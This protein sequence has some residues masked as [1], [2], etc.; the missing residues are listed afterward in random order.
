MR[1]KT[2]KVLHRLCDLSMIGH[3]LDSARALDPDRL[4]VVVGHGRQAVTDHLAGLPPGAGAPIEPV[5]Q[6][7]QR[8]TGHAVR[9]VVEISGL[10]SGTVVVGCGDIPLLRHETLAELTRA[11]EAAGNAVT[12]LSGRFQDPTGYGRIVRDGSGALREIVEHREATTAQREITEVN[13]GVYA[14][15]AGLLSSAVTRLAA[16]NARGEEQLTDAVGLL[17]SDGYRV[18]SVLAPDSAEIFGVND[19]VQLG[20]VHRLRN[21]RLLAHWMHAG[22]AVVDPRSTWLGVDVTL[23]PDA[24]IHPNTRLTGRT[25]VAETAAVGPDCALHDT[26][27]GPGATVRN[28]VGEGAEIGPEASVG[29]Y[30][31]LRSGTKLARKARAGTHVETKNAEIGVDAKV[32]HLTYVGDATIGEGTNIG[33]ATVFVNYDGQTKHHTRVGEHVSVGSDTILVAPLHIGDGAYTAAG[34][35]ITED[36]PPGALGVARERQRNV[37]GW[38]QRRRSGTPSAEAARKAEGESRAHHEGPDPSTHEGA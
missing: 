22:V 16:G 10:P 20:Q 27:V 33:A 7:P 3:V 13:S 29:P 32:P 38:V 12:V 34:S 11:H 18:G 24:T 15:D 35:V 9:S 21:E 1:S 28:A 36:V 4:F 23:E 2:P 26:Y 37:E 6:D 14:F 30:T 19:R 17:G 8:G 5:A 31:Y 25:H